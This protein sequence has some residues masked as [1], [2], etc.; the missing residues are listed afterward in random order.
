MLTKK[1]IISKGSVFRIYWDL[2]INGA[3]VASG[4]ADLYSSS[5]VTDSSYN[6]YFVL[7]DIVTALF[8]DIDEVI[9]DD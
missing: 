1:I 7:N 4:R 9:I 6:V 3:S 2:L 8:T 5:L